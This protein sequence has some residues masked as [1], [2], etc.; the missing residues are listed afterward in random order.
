MDDGSRG[1]P[2]DAQQLERAHYFLVKLK[3]RM[4]LS[5]AFCFALTVMACVI[6]STSG[7][8]RRPQPY[9]GIP[10]DN[11]KEAVDPQIVNK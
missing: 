3:D 6:V 2:R 4:K 11:A 5:R 1:S 9:A 7:C 8:D 10:L